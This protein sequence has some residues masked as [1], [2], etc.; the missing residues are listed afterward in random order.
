VQCCFCQIIGASIDCQA[1]CMPF[2]IHLSREQRIPL[3]SLLITET[4]HT[5]STLPH[6]HVNRICSTFLFSLRIGVFSVD[7]G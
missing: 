5:I 7:F 2:P 1:S 3:H 6:H 4:S